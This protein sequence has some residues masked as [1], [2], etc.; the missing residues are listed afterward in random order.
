MSQ[1]LGRR[2]VEWDDDEEHYPWFDAEGCHYPEP[3]FTH[4]RLLVPLP[5]GAADAE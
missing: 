5:V 4:W 3:A 1:H 2:I